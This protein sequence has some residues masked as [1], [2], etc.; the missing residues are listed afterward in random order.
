MNSQIRT[1]DFINI[2]AAISLVNNKVIKKS[3]YKQGNK[4]YSQKKS[5]SH[6]NNIEEINE[7]VS[8]LNYGTG[9]KKITMSWIK[10]CR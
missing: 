2:N 5:L 7:A 1:E 9:N 6:N 10:K 8:D 4:N 3:P